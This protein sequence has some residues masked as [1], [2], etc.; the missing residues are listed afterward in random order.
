MLVVPRQCQHLTNIS[1]AV[2]QF[3]AGIPPK[4]YGQWVAEKKFHF[5]K[6]QY[7]FYHIL[8]INTFKHV[9][10]YTYTYKIFSLIGLKLL[11]P[12]YLS[13]TARSGSF[14]NLQEN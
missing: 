13:K 8:F 10:I 6:L 9:H 3:L 2:F 7:S 1:G 5:H 14:S 4:L 11:L 12:L